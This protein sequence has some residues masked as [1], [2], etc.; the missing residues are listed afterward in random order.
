VDKNY[1]EA[2]EEVEKYAT[3][4]P[5][6]TEIGFRKLS[7]L[8]SRHHAHLERPPPPPQQQQQVDPGPNALDP[9]CLLFISHADFSNHLKGMRPSPS[10]SPPC[11][12][13]ESHKVSVKARAK[14]NA[15]F[16]FL[17]HCV[18]LKLLKPEAVAE[19]LVAAKGAHYNAI[20][21]LF[22]SKPKPYCKTYCS[23]IQ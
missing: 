7:K 4:N 2:K 3:H 10:S 23:R 22:G 17:G 5:T 6:R 8:A 15:D 16:C 14:A 1:Q 11:T 21:N 19:L 18:F 20:F 12:L 13:L 9:R